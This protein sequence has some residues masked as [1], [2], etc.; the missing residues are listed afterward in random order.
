MQRSDSHGLQSMS[1]NLHVSKAKKRFLSGVSDSNRVGSDG[2]DPDNPCS[3]G[4][5]GPSG[6]FSPGGEPHSGSPL[7][8]GATVSQTDDRAGSFYSVCGSL[9][10]VGASSPS[11]SV[12]GKSGE[13]NKTRARS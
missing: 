9:T 2:N 6:L 10:P 7:A 8:S 11:H 4:N 1:L 13:T 12:L 5:L 3:V